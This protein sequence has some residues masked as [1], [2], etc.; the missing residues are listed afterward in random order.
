MQAPYSFLNWSRLTTQQG[1]RLTRDSAGGYSRGHL[2]K[3]IV[4]LL[5]SLGRGRQTCF[6]G[7]LVISSAYLGPRHPLKTA[8]L[9]TWG[10]QVSE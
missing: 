8:L 9:R 4:L 2:V 1:A 10:A 6:I 5:V 3:P 7:H